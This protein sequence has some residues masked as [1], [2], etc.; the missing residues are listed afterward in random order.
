MSCEAIQFWSGK[1]PWDER[2]WVFN[3]VIYADTI[4]MMILPGR[5]DSFYME[6]IKV[7]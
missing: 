7:T 4:L 5:R 3:P 2:S 1:V 6:E